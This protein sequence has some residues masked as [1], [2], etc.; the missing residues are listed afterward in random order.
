[1]QRMRIGAMAVAPLRGPEGEVLG[2]LAVSWA[3]PQP[4]PEDRVRLLEAL[5]DQAAVALLNSRLYERQ[6]VSEERYR[7][8]VERSPDLVFQLDHDGRFT[9]LSEGAFPLTGYQ[10]AEL[11]GR[12]FSVVTGEDSLPE[13]SAL[14]ERI[15]S[16]EEQVPR[17]RLLNRRKDG[18]TNPIEIHAARVEIGGRFAGM[19]GAG[20][21]LSEA[22][23]LERELRRQTADIAGAEER[24]HLARELHDSVTQALFSMTLTTRSIEL[25][26]PRDP[27]AARERLADLRGLQKDALAEM[28]ALVFALRPGSLE[29]DGLVQ[30]LRTYAAALEQRSGLPVAVEAHADERLAPEVEDTLYRIAQEALHNVVKHARAGRA[31][32]SVVADDVEARL[33]VE[34]DGLG[35]DAERSRPAT[36]VSPG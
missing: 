14:W 33:V 17:I 13:V 8:L 20:R 32:V 29:K 31:R 19:Q 23:R 2:T 4:V 12:H 6:R 30:A 36:S 25:L 16:G 28:R 11:L 3:T 5:A 22:E 26:V 9:F 1:M 27:A 24:A 7:F 21:D 18:S 34:D 10:P 35:F 15:V